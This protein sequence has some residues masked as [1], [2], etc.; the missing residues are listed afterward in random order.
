MESCVKNLEQNEETL[1][2]AVFTS[3]RAYFLEN[4]WQSYCLV[5]TKDSHLPTAPMEIC[6]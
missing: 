6:P 3:I 2:V 4:K 1:V 5:T